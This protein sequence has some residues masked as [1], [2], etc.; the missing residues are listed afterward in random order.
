MSTFNADMGDLIPIEFGA[1]DSDGFTFLPSETVSLNIW[2]KSSGETLYYDFG[3]DDG[4][5]DTLTGCVSISGSMTP[6][7]ETETYDFLWN[8]R[9]RAGFYTARIV[10]STDGSV[11]K[12]KKTETIYV[13]EDK[14]YR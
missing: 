7:T 8:A 5:F 9:N 3:L 13:S 6:N 12:G 11:A 14:R 2:D 10:N 1:F 4:T